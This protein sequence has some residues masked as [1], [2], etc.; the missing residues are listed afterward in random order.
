M[1]VNVFV[2]RLA[3]AMVKP[4]SETAK[5]FGGDF[6]NVAIISDFFSSV[7][8]FPSTFLLHVYHRAG[9]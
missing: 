1:K 7:S 5:D 6:W 4:D 3:A 2:G 9:S 8:F